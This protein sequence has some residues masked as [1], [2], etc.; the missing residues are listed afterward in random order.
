ML[1]CVIVVTQSSDVL[2]RTKIGEHAQCQEIVGSSPGEVIQCASKVWQ[3]K[4]FTSTQIL[5]ESNYG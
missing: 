2:I 4:S 1:G 3:F 5:R